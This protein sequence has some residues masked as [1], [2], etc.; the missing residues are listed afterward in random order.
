[1][2]LS[3]HPASDIFP[4]VDADIQEL[5]ADI[6]AN[7]QLEPILLLDGK[8]LDGRTRYRACEGLGVEPLTKDVEID[9]DSVIAFVVSLNLKRRHLNESQRAIAAAKIKDY[10][11]DNKM[12]KTLVKGDGLLGN[13]SKDDSGSTFMEVAEKDGDQWS[14]RAGKV[15]S[16]S[17]RSVRKADKLLTNGTR[18]LKEAAESGEVRISTA[19]KL[20][21]LSQGEQR[22][23][24]AGGRKEMIVVAKAMTPP[25]KVRLKTNGKIRVA[26]LLDSLKWLSAQMEEMETHRED[27]RVILANQLEEALSLV[28][29][30]AQFLGINVD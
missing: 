3:F 7:G 26:Q 9:K 30:S 16:V 12:K 21:E 18:E 13:I 23:A 17:G 19:V 22:K 20:A 1:M 27:A 2:S 6:K 11:N 15:F 14:E 28:A 24:V 10:F 4:L 5:Q 8:I 29:E 25:M